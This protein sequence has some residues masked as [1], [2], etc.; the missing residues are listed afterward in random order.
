MEQ[1]NIIFTVF[2]PVPNSHQFKNPSD[3]TQG[4]TYGNTC[5]QLTRVHCRVREREEHWW[6]KHCSV[7]FEEHM[8]G[9][10]LFI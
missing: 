1:T 10:V 3:C 4:R 6:L 8:T 5:A 2:F 9:K 7:L